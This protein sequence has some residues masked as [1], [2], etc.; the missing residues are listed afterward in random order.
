MPRGFGPWETVRYWHGRFRRDGLWADL[1]ALLIRAVRQLEG[2]AAEPAT[3]ILDSQSVVSGPQKG[4]RGLD[5][6]KKIK[7]IKRHTLTCSL[8]FVLSV[9]VTKAVR[10]GKDGLHVIAGGG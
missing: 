4:E 9:L 5:G 1:S 7:G 2:R 10:G 6:H 8:G 3:A